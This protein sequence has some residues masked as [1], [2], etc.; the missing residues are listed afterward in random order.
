MFCVI[1]NHILLILILC[2]IL[3]YI[4]L[5]LCIILYYI[6]IVLSSA[7]FVIRTYSSRIVRSICLL[8]IMCSFIV[9]SKIFKTIGVIAFSMVLN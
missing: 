4:I 1:L 6:I 3:Y 8:G 2:I 5:I 7:H 9:Y